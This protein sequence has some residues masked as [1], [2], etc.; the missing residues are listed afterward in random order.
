MIN[1]SILIS[2]SEVSGPGGLFDFNLTL[3]LVAIQFLL[4]MVILNVILYNPLL[5]ITDERKN[6]VNVK[7]AD[8]Q[9]F[10][11]EG[12]ELNA[13]YQQELKNIR[14]EAES[15]ITTLQQT[16]KTGFASE[17]AV[18]DTEIK[19][20]VDNAKLSIQSAK[21]ETLHT[22]DEI[23]LFLS[24]EIEHKLHINFWRDDKP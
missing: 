23:I 12:E 3:P 9:K 8:S 1:F 24:S 14:K 11:Q 2:S 20:L 16:Y 22:V 13:M 5:T 18:L 19:S 6:F 21:N 17:L 15:E 7:V 4:L 10:S